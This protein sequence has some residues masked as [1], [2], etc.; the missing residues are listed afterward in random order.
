M[1]HLVFVV[2]F[3]SKE[4]DLNVFPG[5]AELSTV[6]WTTPVTGKKIH[7]LTV[8]TGLVQLTI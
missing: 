2:S 5:N 8:V 4:S 7:S 3:I 1:I 6:A